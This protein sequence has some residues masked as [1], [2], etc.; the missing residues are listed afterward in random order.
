MQLVK[1]PNVHCN[2]E[3]MQV[4]EDV[5]VYDVHGSFDLLLPQNTTCTTNICTFTSVLPP[6]VIVVEPFTG[7][8]NY[9]VIDLITIT[10]SLGR[11]IQKQSYLQM[12]RFFKQSPLSYF[13]V[14]HP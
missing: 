2:L 8:M 13:A 14:S 11:R 1:F 6:P 4:L 10:T 9:D 5:V 7:I 3:I 12:H